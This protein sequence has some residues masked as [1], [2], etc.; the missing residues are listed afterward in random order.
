MDEAARQAAEGAA[1]LAK[2]EK[3]DRKAREK[4]LRRKQRALE[5]KAIEDE[6]AQV[7][8]EMEGQHG[9]SA[10]FQIAESSGNSANT[11]TTGSSFTLDSDLST[12]TSTICTFG[13]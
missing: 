11:I 13:Y 6:L 10:N 1:L 8:A 2:M 3:A 9:G 4:A 12:L 5:A 7:E